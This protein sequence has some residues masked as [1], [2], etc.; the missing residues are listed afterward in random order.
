NRS[1]RRQKMTILTGTRVTGVDISGEGVTVVATASRGEQAVTADA[2]I[3]AIGIKPNTENLGLE[4]AGINPNGGFIPVDAFGRTTTPG[5]FAIGDVTGP[6]FLAHKASA[7]ALACIDFIAG[8]NP[9]PVRMDHIPGCTYCNPQVASVGLTEAAA[10]IRGID[11]ITGT[12]PFRANGRSIAMNE[13][14]GIVKL[15]F[16][17]ADRNRFVGAHILHAMA[18]ELIAELGLALTVG[19]TATD[20]VHT[21]HAHPTLSEAVMEAAEDALGRPIHK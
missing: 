13:S 8:L 3:V 9:V 18:S 1:L 5:I 14:E 12:F 6:P 20:I 21:V 7:Q 2:V 4:A 15:V 11:A 16:D 17:R 19:A 10:R